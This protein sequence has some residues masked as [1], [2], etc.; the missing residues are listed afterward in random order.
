[1]NYAAQ[2]FGN[3]KVKLLLLVS[4]SYSPCFLC[5]SVQARKLYILSQSVST[6]NEF[7]YQGYELKS[8]T[9][10][11]FDFFDRLTFALFPGTVGKALD[12]KEKDTKTA[13]IMI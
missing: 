6:L 9:Q 3:Y 2:I 8:N 7:H 12:I 13:W 11:E 5:S 4:W 1:M 10:A